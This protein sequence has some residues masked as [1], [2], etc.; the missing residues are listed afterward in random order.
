[1]RGI[2]SPFIKIYERGRDTPHPQPLALY[3]R[4]KT[5]L[6]DYEHALYLFEGLRTTG[7][8]LQLELSSGLRK[9]GDWS[10]LASAVR[11]AIQSPLE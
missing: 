8:G 2:P 9:A 1:M 7:E 10:G 5:Y 6:P 4:V 11:Y 3:Y